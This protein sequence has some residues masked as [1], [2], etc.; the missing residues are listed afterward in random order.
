M[1]IAITHNWYL[2]QNNSQKV[3]LKKGE[4]YW[5]LLK[6]LRIELSTY[7]KLFVI[8]IIGLLLQIHTH[9]KRRTMHTCSSYVEI[10]K[11]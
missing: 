6:L 2:T 5:Y 9:T 4:I 3:E 8:P 1:V 10:Q 11:N 7:E